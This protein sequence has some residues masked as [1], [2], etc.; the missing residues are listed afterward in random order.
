[1]K[2]SKVI[3]LSVTGAMLLSVAGAASY[4]TFTATE[5]P[6]VKIVMDG[7][8]QKLKDG[9]GN[10]VNPVVINGTTYLPLRATAGLFDKAVNWN[11]ATSTITLGEKV[12]VERSLFDA[13]KAMKKSNSLASAVKG[14][15]NLTFDIG[16][17]GVSY[18][19]AIKITNYFEEFDVVLNE[20]Y[21]ELNVSLLA[22]GS[23]GDGV[24]SII[25]K[26]TGVEI[27]SRKVKA[28]EI[29]EI[30]EIDIK[31]VRNL[32]FKVSKDI[33]HDISEWYFLNPT[34]K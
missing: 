4:K 16:E 14:K 31:N 7:Q 29:C 23:R 9:N 19:S 2:K 21:E 20:G 3:A 27:L 32:Q 11:G 24:F 22:M 33:L 13:A 5:R 10:A 25:D 6:D 1:M 34:V 12:A 18:D 26:D 8:V 30:N 28:G 15:Q 17:M